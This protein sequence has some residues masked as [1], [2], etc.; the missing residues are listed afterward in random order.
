MATTEHATANAPLNM[1]SRP[2]KSGIRS[3]PRRRSTTMRMTKKA[4]EK[5]PLLPPKVVTVVTPKKTTSEH[6]G[7]SLW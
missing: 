5:S 6:E 2:R 3:S 7:R 4:K 1:P